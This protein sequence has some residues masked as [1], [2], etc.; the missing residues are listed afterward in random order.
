MISENIPKNLRMI[1]KTEF[2]FVVEREKMIRSLHSN[3]E[4]LLFLSFDFQVDKI[5]TRKLL[6]AIEMILFID[7]SRLYYS[8]DNPSIIIIILPNEIE[9]HPYSTDILYYTTDFVLQGLFVTKTEKESFRY[10][11]TTFA[12]SSTML[13]DDAIDEGLPT[14]IIEHRQLNNILCPNQRFSVSFKL[15][16]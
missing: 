2:V 4:H 5:S 10:W 1:D 9:I 15:L 11:C 3:W 8:R 7:W 16:K 6:V 12:E 13:L 14:S